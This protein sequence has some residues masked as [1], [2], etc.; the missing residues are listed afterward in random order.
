MVMM[1]ATMDQRGHSSFDF[2]QVSGSVN[3]KTQFQVV[4]SASLPCSPCRVVNGFRNSEPGTWKSFRHSQVV[5]PVLQFTPT[6]EVTLT[7]TSE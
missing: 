1:M 7:R 3:P 2:M 5:R 4:N 6:L